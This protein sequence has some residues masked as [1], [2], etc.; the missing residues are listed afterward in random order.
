MWRLFP[1]LLYITAGKEDDVDGGFA[2]EYLAPV[3]TC[4]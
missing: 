2:Y 1:Q 4:I 3:I